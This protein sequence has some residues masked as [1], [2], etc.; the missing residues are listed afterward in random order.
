MPPVGNNPQAPQQERESRR[1]SQEIVKRGNAI[2]AGV[3]FFDPTIYFP[4]RVVM[5][6][7]K[8]GIIAQNQKFK[9]LPTELQSYLAF[10]IRKEEEEIMI[11]EEALEIDRQQRN[12]SYI[13]GEP[14]DEIHRLDPEDDAVRIEQIL[15]SLQDQN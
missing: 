14:K 9:D 1:F 15:K 12:N 10:R 4:M 13:F 11:I 7:K 8:E 3:S 5:S 6:A 2:L